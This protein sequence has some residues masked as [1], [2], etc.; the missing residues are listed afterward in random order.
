[1][2]F[3]LPETITKLWKENKRKQ[4]KTEKQPKFVSYFLVNIVYVVQSSVERERERGKKL[5]QIEQSYTSEMWKIVSASVNIWPS[6]EIIITI[7]ET[8]KLIL[9][10]CCCCSR[11]AVCSLYMFSV[12]LPVAD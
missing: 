2:S 10:S 11:V 9:T 5:N 6:I 1:M 12:L 8:K 4:K 7:T 3:L